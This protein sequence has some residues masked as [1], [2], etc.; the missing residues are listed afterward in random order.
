[1]QDPVGYLVNRPRSLTGTQGVAFD[2]VMAQ[3]GLLVQARNHLIAAR[4]L[5]APARVRGLAPAPPTLTLTHGPI[6]HQLL[7]QGLAWMQ[8]SPSRERLF[9]VIH[10][11]GAYQLHLPRQ[12]GR[13]TGI[14]Y[15]PVQ[16]AIL[17]VHSHGALPAFF[18]STDDRDEQG[19]RIYGVTG[20]LRQPRPQLTLRMGV[21]GHF[22]PLH[23]N[24]VFGAIPPTPPFL[25]AHQEPRPRQNQA[26]PPRGREE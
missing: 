5:L 18:S 2:Y 17:E 1:M 11:D 3:E 10:R 7:A 13:T 15:Q 16:E 9:A 21:Y 22:A 19:L 24:Q 12:T 14:T 23:P 25:P 8:Q 4:I 6:P 20:H 26:R